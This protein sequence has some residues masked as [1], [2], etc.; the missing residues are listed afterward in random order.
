MSDLAQRIVNDL[1]SSSPSLA[2]DDQGDTSTLDLA[3]TVPTR[4]LGGIDLST[5]DKVSVSDHFYV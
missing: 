2:N 1:E 3:A 5:N 4:V